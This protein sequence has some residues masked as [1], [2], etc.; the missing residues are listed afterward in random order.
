ML[1]ERE[2][3]T[4]WKIETIG[5][6]DEHQFIGIYRTALKDNMECEQF[7]LL[8]TEYSDDVLIQ[9]RIYKNGDILL[10]NLV[11]ANVVVFKKRKLVTIELLCEILVS[12]DGE[13]TIRPTFDYR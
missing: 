13:M 11:P 3:F 9:L 8:P 4:P 5:L 12:T 7:T 2:P 6:Q 10:G 1:Y